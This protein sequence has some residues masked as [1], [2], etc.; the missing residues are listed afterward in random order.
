MQIF[1]NT[2]YDFIRWRWHALIL[3][4]ALIIGGL[5]FALATQAACRSAST[6]RAARMVVLQFEQPV[7]EDAG[8][9]GARRA[10]RRQGRPAVRRRRGAPD[11]DPAAAGRPT[12]SRA[13]ASSRAPRAPSTRSRRRACRKFEVDQHARSSARSSAPTCSRRASTRRCASILGLTVYIALPLPVHLRRRR[14]RRDVPR[15]LH[16]VRVARL[17]RLRA[18]AEHRRRDADDHRLLGERHHRHL[19]PRARERAAAAPRAA[20]QGRQPERQP[21][22]GPDDHHRRASR[23]SSV[24]A[25]YLFGGEV[26]RGFAFA[27][28][29][30]IIS[31][32]YSTVFIAATIAIILSGRKA[33]AGRAAVPVEEAVERPAQGRPQR[34]GVVSR[35]AGAVLL[36]HAALLGVVQGL[37][38]FL[39]V[40][41]SAHLILA[42]AFFGWDAEQFGRP[43][44][45]A[46]HVGTLAAILVYF[47]HDLHRAWSTALPRAFQPRRGSDRAPALAD[48]RRHD[49]AGADRACCWRTSRTRSARRR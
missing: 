32:T 10:A 47:R 4:S 28:L 23:S 29:V 25:L 5:V 20:R 49:P 41:S 14:D 11:P 15:H 18:V 17:L 7:H 45:V 9:Q 16:R 2:N 46:C 34:A 40:S 3:S 19:R 35:R 8:P 26:L 48:R 21:D 37:T 1:H 36:L 6:S 22:A 12:R 13:S 38:E 33:S 27:M 30:G 31:G 42:R 24:L 39:P 44:D 43:F